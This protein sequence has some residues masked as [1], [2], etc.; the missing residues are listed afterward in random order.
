MRMVRV[1]PSRSSS[2]FYEQHTRVEFEWDFADLIE[3]DGFPVCQFTGT[4]G[5]DQPHN[6]CSHPF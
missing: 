3:R 2:G 1:L 5:F 4:D 6:H